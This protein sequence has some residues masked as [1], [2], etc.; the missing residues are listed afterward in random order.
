MTRDSEDRLQSQSEAVEEVSTGGGRPPRERWSARGA[1]RDA[2]QPLRDSL[3]GTR[4]WF[5]GLPRGLRYLVLAG[6]IGGAAVVPFIMNATLGFQSQYWMNIVTKIGIG[7]LLA[8]GLNVVVGFAGLLDLGYVA[9]FA[10]GAYTYA[11]LTGAARYSVLIE[12]QTPEATKLAAKIRP[13]WH[14]Y[15]WLF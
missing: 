11:L 7:V 10:V 1:Y 9:F 13:E 2:T 4:T 5:E 6:L 12:A 14:M 8:L 15:M 3:A